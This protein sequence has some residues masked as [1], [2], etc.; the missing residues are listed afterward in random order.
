LWQNQFSD[1]K[2]TCS[3]V[4][5]KQHAKFTLTK[6]IEKLDSAV[7]SLQKKKRSVF[8]SLK[9][10]QAAMTYLSD[11]LAEVK[12][13][14]L[15]NNVSTLEQK[16]NSFSWFCKNAKTSKDQNIKEAMLEFQK[17]CMNCSEDDLTSSEKVRIVFIVKLSFF[18]TLCLSSYGL[19]LLLSL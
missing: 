4:D 17:Y 9:C 14:D 15:T 6:E 8:V 2:P 5:V 12:M 18:L 1:I 7:E 19:L 3:T 16:L 11:Q 10:A 13:A